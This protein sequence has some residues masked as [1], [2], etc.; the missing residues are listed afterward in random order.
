MDPEHAD[1]FL[2]LTSLHGPLATPV[3]S[4]YP[5]ALGVRAVVRALSLN[6]VITA[7]RLVE[8]FGLLEIDLMKPIEIEH[9]GQVHVEIEPKRLLGR[10][11]GLQ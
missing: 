2:R 1:V 6:G 11:A 7:A 10:L 9:R 3:N 4:D 8:L 5:S